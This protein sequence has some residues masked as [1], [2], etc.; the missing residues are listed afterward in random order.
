[1][2]GIKKMA[3]CP[4]CKKEFARTA[5]HERKKYKN[6]YTC[7]NSSRN[8]IGPPLKNTPSAFWRYVEKTEACWLWT[9]PKMTRGYGLYFM[10]GK[11]RGAH[12][13]AYEFTYG[14]IPEGLLAC[15]KCD[16]PPCVRPDHLFLGTVGDNMADA[17]RKGR[18]RTKP[19]PGQDNPRAKLTDFSVLAI[20]K[21]MA[22][23]VTRKQLQHQFKDICISTLDKIIYNQTWKHLPPTQKP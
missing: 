20:R 11:R 18:S 6:C 12:R 23:G 21:A 14:Q 9:G 8:F 10:N 3:I 2:G 17:A 5:A 1:M 19:R 15:H 7:R 4:R 13:L 16:N 22:S